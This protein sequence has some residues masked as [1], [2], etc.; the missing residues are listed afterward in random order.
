MTMTLEHL[1]DETLNAFVDGELAGSEHAMVE[2]HLRGCGLCG[3]HVRAAMQL[4]SATARSGR[5][6]TPSAQTLTRL[7]AGV[8]AKPRPRV[9]PAAWAAVAAAIVLA[10]ALAVW[11]PLR[12]ADTLSAELLDQHLATLSSGATP[13]VISSDRHTVK[14]WFQ[15]RLPFSFSLPEILPADTRL[16]GAD[17]AFVNGQ[18][19]AL[20][21]FTVHKHEVSVFL[22]Q[23]T[24]RPALPAGRSGFVIRSAEANNLTIIAVSDLNPTE[25]GVLLAALV[26]AQSETP[27][28]E[29]N[30]GPV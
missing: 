3:L 12:P 25:L 8:E 16:K 20:L 19:A 18:P 28:S 30:A 26:S 9:W 23:H 13:Q 21:L 5:R 6:F 11:R 15:G 1:S 17:L 29:K 7:T 22:Y 27:L 4:K 10:V 14:P 24:G 2:G